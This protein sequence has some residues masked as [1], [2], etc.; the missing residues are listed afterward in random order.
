MPHDPSARFQRSSL[1]FGKFHHEPETLLYVVLSAADLL[2][3]YFLLHQDHDNLRFV[4]SNP[5]ARF[6]LDRWGIS[7]MIYFKFSMVAFVCL[8]TQIIARWRPVTA[9]LVLWFAIVVMIYV[10]VYSARL[11][12]THAPRPTAT[13]PRGEVL[14]IL[15][16]DSVNETGPVGKTY[17][18]SRGIEATTRLSL[19]QI[20]PAPKPSSVGSSV[21]GA[22]DRQMDSRFGL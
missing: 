4:E 13:N 9:R 5:V 3:T 2:I 22:I 17:G 7:G 12:R 21:A 8:V 14:S 15:N 18:A 6:F 20:K 16:A 19:T 1:L 11:Y 10:V